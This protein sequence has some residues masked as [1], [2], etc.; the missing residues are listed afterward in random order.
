MSKD[1]HTIG[2]S[3]YERT[4]LD[5]YPTPK[6]CIGAL[7]K[8]ITQDCGMVW[9]PCAGN[10]AISNVLSDNGYSVFSSDIKSYD[11]FDLD[12]VKDFYEL[13]AIPFQRDDSKGANVALV[14]NPP[15]VNSRGFIKH[16]L[17]IKGVD[18]W[19]FLLRHEWDAPAASIPIVTDKRFEGKYILKKRPR[20]IE[21]TTTAPRFPYAW[22]HW[23]VS[24]SG[25]PRI[26]YGVD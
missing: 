20:W 26:V 19:W 24:N 7:L 12:L 11:G 8:F 18:E 10:G 4:A 14:T 5:F 3:Q 15:Y 2:P 16:A 1:Q 25:S 17:D 13:K 9:E 21:G 6:S 23:S 22:Y